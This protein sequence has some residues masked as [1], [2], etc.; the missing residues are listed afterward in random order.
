[1]KF[2]KAYCW[3]DFGEKA[4]SFDNITARVARP[5]K[6]KLFT[7]PSDHVPRRVDDFEK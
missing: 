7:T 4:V 2:G 6:K 5:V 1:M 3:T